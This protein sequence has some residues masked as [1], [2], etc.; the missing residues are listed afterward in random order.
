MILSLAS[1]ANLR[2]VPSL[3]NLFT[4]RVHPCV[5]IRREGRL[6]R[7]EVTV[8]QLTAGE[9]FLASEAV[10]RLFAGPDFPINILPLDTL[11]TH[12]LDEPV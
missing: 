9:L 2:R 10:E 4:A 6:L 1:Y 7:M 5:R 12:V 8:L 3:S 11:F